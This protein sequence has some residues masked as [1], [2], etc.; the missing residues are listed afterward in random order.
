LVLSVPFSFTEKNQ[1]RAVMDDDGNI[2]HLM[3]PCYHGDPLSEDGVL[4]YC[5]FG[6]ELLTEMRAA[7]FQESHL[8]CYCSRQ[9]GYLHNNVVFIGLKLKD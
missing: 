7:G 2:T 4:S 8:L 6:M 9:W 5:D 1:V 3:E